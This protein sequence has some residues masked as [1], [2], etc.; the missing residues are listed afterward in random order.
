[1]QNTKPFWRSKTLWLNTLVA[2]LTML[3]SQFALLQPQ[4]EPAHYILLLSA[5]AGV[6]VFLRTVTHQ[7]VEFKN[8]VDN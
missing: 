7:K 4:L 6:N 2:V 3:E 1:M 8:H 5:L